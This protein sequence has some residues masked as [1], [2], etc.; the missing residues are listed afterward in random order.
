MGLAAAEAHQFH[1]L[2]VDDSI[3]DRKLIER[4]LKTS[5][6]QVTAVDSGSKALEFLGLH[7]QDDQSAADIP[8]LSPDNHHQEVEVNLIIT[9]YCMPGMTGYDLLRKIK[10][11]NVLKDIPVVIMSSENEPSRINRCLEEGAEE[12][13]LKPVQLS[14]VNK[15]R[16]HMLKG[17]SKERLLHLYKFSTL[18]LSLSHY[19]PPLFR[20]LSFS[21]Q[22]ELISDTNTVPR[23]KRRREPWKSPPL[24]PP[25]LAALP[26]RLG[27]NSV[28]FR[29]HCC[30][31]SSSPSSIPSCLE[32]GSERTSIRIT[33]LR[34]E[35]QSTALIE[36]LARERA[37]DLELR[38]EAMG[39]A[40][41]AM[42]AIT[43]LKKGAQLLKYGRRGKPKFCPF[44]LSNDESVLIWYSGKE[45][46]YVK[47]SQVSRIV[48][49]QRT[50][51][52]QRY[53]RPEKE[54]QSFSLI[55]ND[56]SLD[57]ICKDKDEAEVW[58]T[59][60][61]ALISRGLHQKGRPESRSGI[62]SEANSPRSHTQQ[63]S[64]LSSPFC[65]GDS[66][67]KDGVEPFHLHA[68]FESPPKIGLEKALSD[69]MLYALP[70][71]IPF[72][73]DA[74]CG[75]VPSPGG[76]DGM[77]GRTKGA[78]VDAFRVS[79][80]SAVSSSSQGSGHDEV[81]ALGDVFIWG[82]GV[83][84][85]SG[86]SKRNKKMD[87]SSN[88]VIPIANGVSER[89][90]L[91]GTRSFNPVFGSSK[92]FFSAS[93]PGSRIASRATSPTLRRSSPPRSTTP[94]PALS[95]LTLPKVGDDAKRKNV[96]LSEEVLKLKAQVEDLTRKAQLRE[97]EMEKTGQQLKEALK[98]AGEETVKCKA[99]KEVIK[100]LTAQLKEMAERLP[101]GTARN[102]DTRPLDSS[103]P[104]R[105]V[106]TTAVE[107]TSSTLNFSE[108]YSI[109]SSSEIISDVPRAT[110]N[111][112]EVA[113]SEATARHKN[114]GAKA[115]TA[116][117][118][119]WVEQ[120]EPGV[121]ITLVSLPGGVKDLKRVR[122]SRKRFSEKQA[123][124]WWAANKGRVYQQYNVPVVEKSSIPTGREGLAH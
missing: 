97:I 79:L 101:I 28:L 15:L 123:E 23:S 61:K 89:R 18:S 17:R 45:E 122:F 64:P 84:M 90:A 119:E 100:S 27:T 77:N 47:L 99:A 9:D 29:R 78:G 57:L 75:S 116:Q 69:V 115:E 87:F 118:D 121:Y 49:G 26:R 109:V 72:P 107:K 111:H 1:V 59:G 117:G 42:E 35:V 3:I 39:G 85:E 76:S 66:S 70:P 67:Q 40:V 62:T 56:R 98:V 19:F 10:E 102:M 31:S 7:E 108:P 110:S 114:R 20:S 103:S 73:S 60:L 96:S 44:R 68:A 14:D 37:R 80:S 24:Q 4:L 120:D 2:A 22:P 95:G 94:T 48:P 34:R 91:N 43:A 55:C 92:K 5:S 93:L 104:T 33:D 36:S 113:H 25:F 50:Q 46:K 83:E 53:P 8:S 82:E 51:T 12:F 71:K 54:Y 63:S 106:S 112:T 52:F 81:D 105:E 32:F 38:K 58:F 6:Y 30:Y 11:S 88:C 21:A 86:S 13:F 124:Q 74:A 65:S 16:P 41:V